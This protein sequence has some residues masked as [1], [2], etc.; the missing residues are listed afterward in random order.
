MTNRPFEYDRHDDND[1]PYPIE[2]DRFFFVVVNMF[3]GVYEYVSAV[4][5]GQGPS[6]GS[7]ACTGWDT[8]PSLA[9]PVA[10]LLY[11]N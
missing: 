1:E 5:F 6:P 4:G 3:V 11:K 8:C 10:S 2:Y 9:S 7:Q